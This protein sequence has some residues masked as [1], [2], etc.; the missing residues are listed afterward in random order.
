MEKKKINDFI[1]WYNQNGNVIAIENTATGIIT[2][3]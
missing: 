2:Y 3:L 1:F